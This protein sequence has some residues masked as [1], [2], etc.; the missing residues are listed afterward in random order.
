MNTTVKDK[1]M[2]FL[3][4]GFLGILSIFCW[5]KPNT[6]YSDS[7]RRMLAGFP[8]LTA[9]TVTSGKF[10]KDF[11]TYTLDQ[12]PLRDTF[13]G[14]KSFSALYLFGQS[15]VNDLYLSQGYITKQEYPVN[16]YMLENAGKKFS[17]L[18][19]TYMK[20]SDCNLYF[21]IVPDKNYFLASL[22][23]NL[24]MD[25]DAFVTSMQEKTSYMKYIDIFNGLSVENYYRTDTHWKQ[26]TLLPT[27]LTLANA[28]GSD[29]ATQY[30]E[31]ELNTPFYGVYYGQLGLPIPP[32]KLTYLTNPILDNCIV[33]SYTTGKP[34]TQPLYDLSKA[35]DKDPY[36]L[37]VCGNTPLV[38]IENPSADTD[39]ELIIF[40]DSFGSSIAPLLAT[41]YAKVTLVD[42]RYI[43]SSILGNYLT[44]QN[45][46]VLFLYST[47][48]LNSSTIFK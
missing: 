12:F 10:M 32:D 17:Y 25:Y 24:S 41:G 1:V 15:E 46:D 13:R 4:A 36:E 27:A 21:S 29:I 2:V 47:L 48:V 35:N 44:F 33:T 18:Y 31:N 26:E 5:L 34:V 38:T 16:E 11:E 14:I 22:T 7:E 19:D 6:T 20:D 23:G 30:T 39:R 37:F 40:R 45:Q 3:M 43:N 9:D 8:K 28:M 42:I